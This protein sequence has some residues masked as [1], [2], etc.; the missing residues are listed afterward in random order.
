MKGVASFPPHFREAQMG[1][2]QPA[3]LTEGS[4]SAAFTPPTRLRRATS[5]FASA[6]KMA[7]TLTAMQGGAE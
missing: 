2:W 6:T 1:R 3:G 5:P 4:F 7:R